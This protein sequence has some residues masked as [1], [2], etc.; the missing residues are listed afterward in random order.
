MKTTVFRFITYRV[1][2]IIKMLNLPLEEG[3]KTERSRNQRI[4]FSG[5]MLYSVMVKPTIF[6]VLCFLVQSNQNSLPAASSMY[7]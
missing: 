5:I 2:V 7:A 1:D 6:R 3:T 4:Q